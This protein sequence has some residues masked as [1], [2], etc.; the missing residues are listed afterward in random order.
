MIRIPVKEIL[1]VASI[2]S[3]CAGC[4]PIT[5]VA[6]GKLPPA[7]PI[8]VALLPPNASTQGLFRETTQSK[9]PDGRTAIKAKN[10]SSLQ[11]LTSERARAFFAKSLPLS[12]SNFKQFMK[13]TGF[14]CDLHGLSECHYT[15]ARP[16]IPCTPSL[17]VSVEVFYGAGQSG[18]VEERN[19]DIAAMIVEDDAPTD[20]R[21][22][23]PL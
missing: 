16:P 17:R 13:E 21:G 11:K 7:D 5:D 14:Q 4:Q 15:K 3:A 1:V 19:L 2:A 12:L 22:C 6:I 18:L 20:D 10:A 9:T 8:W 23:F